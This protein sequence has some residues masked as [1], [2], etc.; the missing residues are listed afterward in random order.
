MNQTLDI[1]L[2]RFHLLLKMTCAAALLL[3]LW[4]AFV[5]IVLWHAA[6]SKRAHKQ[7]KNLLHNAREGGS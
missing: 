3:A 2:S 4:Q 6:A 7:N 1:R 5:S